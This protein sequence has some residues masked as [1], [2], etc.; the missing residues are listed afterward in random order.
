MQLLFNGHIGG[1]QLRLL[2]YMKERVHKALLVGRLVGIGGDDGL[3][4]GLLR[5]AA[6]GQLLHGSDLLLLK[7]YG[8]HLGRGVLGQT[9]PLVGVVVEL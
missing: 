3:G 7:I 4:A 5:L 2:L 1:I 6:E 8:R 9:R